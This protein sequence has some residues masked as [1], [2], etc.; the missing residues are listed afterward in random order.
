M[1]FPVGRSRTE[2]GK[3]LPRYLNS[4]RDNAQELVDKGT[5][6]LG[7]D[8]ATISN[9]TA[10]GDIKIFP[11]IIWL[12]SD[13]RRR[14]EYVSLRSRF[15]I[16]ESRGITSS[17]GQ[18][19]LVRVNYQQSSKKEKQSRERQCDLDPLFL[20]W[21]KV[22]SDEEKFRTLWII[23]NKISVFRVLNVHYFRRQSIFWRRWDK[24]VKNKKEDSILN[25]SRMTLVTSLF[26]FSIRYHFM[27]Y[28]SEENS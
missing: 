5:L 2:Q 13:H 18:T 26:F 12:L 21:G 20:S 1:D 4:I 17:H 24:N 10:V 6:I 22:R 27:R 28:T 8:H 7:C 14:A 23:F 15:I 16:E 9:K 3:P 19:R 11:K 25:R